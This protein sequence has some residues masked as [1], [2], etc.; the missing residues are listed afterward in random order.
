MSA[1]PV[2][3]LLGHRRCLLH[4]QPESETRKCRNTWIRLQVE[5]ADNRR[6]GGAQARE[7]ICPAFLLKCWL[8]AIAYHTWWVPFDGQGTFGK[9]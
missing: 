1:L 9:I 3:T 8:Y 2:E 7:E 4:G 5:V 6:H